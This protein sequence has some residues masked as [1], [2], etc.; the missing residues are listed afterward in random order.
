MA[1]AIECEQKGEYQPFNQQGV[2]EFGI[3]DLS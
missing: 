3:G 1:L 2:T